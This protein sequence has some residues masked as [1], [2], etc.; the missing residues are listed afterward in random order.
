MGMHG[1][2]SWGQ[3]PGETGTLTSNLRSLVHGSNVLPRGMG[4]SYGDVCTNSRGTLLSTAF[5]NK[6]IAFDPSTGVLT[7]ESGVTISE[8]QR[9]FVHRGWM[10][11]VTP[12]TQYVSVGGA[13][14][15]DVHGKNHHAMGTFGNHVLSIGLAR[16]NGDYIMCSPTQQTE[17]FHA[18]IGG[19]G[20]TGLITQATIQLQ[21]VPGP[22]LDTEN[23]AF[24]TMD[25]F[26]AISDKSEAGW[27]YSVAW[28]DC[29]RGK[30]TRG[31]FMRGNH[32]AHPKQQEPK[33]RTLTFGINSPISLVNPV[34]TKL[35]SSAYYA[36]NSR[37]SGI[38]TTH[39]QPFFYPL[40][41]VKHWNRIYGQ[42]GFF[43]HQ[44]VVPRQNGQETLEAMFD[45][46]AQSRQG[47]FL[48]VLKTFGQMPSVGMLSFARAGIT[49]ALDFPNRGSRTLDL[50]NE[51]DAIVMA[52]GGAI[53]PSKDARMSKETF[54]ASFPKAAEFLQWRDPGISS[55]F[56]R[57]ILGS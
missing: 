47:S 16:T 30:S 5:L 25:E 15:N 24:S 23:I 52:A 13:I 28:V 2:P 51:L 38:R 50:L 26:L 3:L 42:R 17:L 18:T 19:L 31:I 44:S 54:A 56:S 49:L 9:L 7:C 32:A 36:M 34:S 21:P 48:S 8:I 41:A 35:I 43:Q 10:V 46:I 22:W 1:A 29:S 39:Y 6:F 11:P 4:R 57:R 45:V 20:L 55:D 37:Q 33:D 14:A 53:N 12:G 40:D 27:K